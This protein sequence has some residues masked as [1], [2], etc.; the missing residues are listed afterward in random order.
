MHKYVIFIMPYSNES[1]CTYNNT[2][3]HLFSYQDA[4]NPSICEYILMVIIITCKSDN[5]LLPQNIECAHMLHP[6][7]EGNYDSKLKYNVNVTFFVLYHLVVVVVVPT[8]SQFIK[9]VVLFFHEAVHGFRCNDI[10]ENNFVPWIWTE[11][12]K[13][14]FSRAVYFQFS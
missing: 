3:A 13:I 9:V 14:F 5:K 8:I 12:S 10:S 1:P 11:L 2:T 4:V 6:F 7:L